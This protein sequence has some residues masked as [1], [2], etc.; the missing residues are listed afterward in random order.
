[1]LFPLRCTL[2]AGRPCKLSC[3]EALAAALYICGLM[4]ESH[5]IMSRF[6]W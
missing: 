4:E 1:M 3:A 6:K 2:P 5:G